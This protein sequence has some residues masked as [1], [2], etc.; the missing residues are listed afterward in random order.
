MLTLDCAEKQLRRSH[1]FLHF[2]IIFL[3]PVQES[4]RYTCVRPFLTD[5]EL[6]ITQHKRYVHL[7]MGKVDVGDSNPLV[8]QVALATPTHR[9]LYVYSVLADAH[10]VVKFSLSELL[11]LFIAR[12]RLVQTT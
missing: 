9:T 12:Q 5:G 3:V 8:D 1:V 11:L 4:V 10:A 7:I 6:E 2:F